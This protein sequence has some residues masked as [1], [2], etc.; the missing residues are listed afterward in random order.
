MSNFVALS[1]AKGLL[2]PQRNSTSRSFAALRTTALLACVATTL[3]AQQPATSAPISAMRYEVT[4]DKAALATRRLHVTTSF[5]VADDAVVLLSLPAWT[6]GAYEI[7]NFAKWVSAFHASEGSA[8]LRWD[9]LDYDT[10]RVRP[11]RGGRVSV[12]FEYSADSLDNA[13]SWTRPDFALFNGTNLFMYPEGRSAEFSST[14]VIKTDATFLVTTGLAGAGANHTYKAPNYHDLVDNPFFVG[15]FDLDSAPIAGKTVRY[16]TYPVGSVSAEARATAWEQLKRVIPV[17]VNVFGEAPWDNYT[18]MQIADSSYQGFSG[19]EHASSHVDIVSPAGIG[20]EFQP[21][22]YAHEI[23]HSW[24]VKR[25]RPADMVP[26]HYDRPQ[27]T[28]WLW[29]SEGITD[30]YADLAEMRGGVVDEAGFF[31]LTAAKIGE[32][33]TTVPFALE[34]ASVNTWVHPT[35]GTEYSYYPKGSLAGL[36][37]DIIVRD[38][39]DNKRSLDTVMRAL[40]ETTYKKDRGF[41]F[42]DFWGAVRRAANGRSFDDFHARY[43]DG[44][45]PYP[46]PE[47]LRTIGLRMVSDSLPR[48]GVSTAPDPAGAVRVMEVA[49]GTPAAAAG[50]QAGDVMVSVGDVQVADAQFG[51]KFRAQ[52]VGRPAGTPIPIVVRRGNDT[53]TLNGALA[54]APSAPRLE[55]DPAA[56]ARAVR[57]RDGILRGTTDR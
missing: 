53:L 37:L 7:T 2:F 26:Y 34:D 20:T 49:P 57:L 25:L 11:T 47:M 8:E 3:G 24:N 23:F 43:V 38:A 28:T 30:Y 6:P 56:P 52:Y 14:V 54:Y 41:G 44:R 40:Y 10:W 33:A 13:M 32:I 39:S 31:A 12:S 35:D 48:I 18:V 1:K 21:S 36:M 19:L 27:P 45:A 42:A 55:E 46:W 50:V 15:R 29:V 9:K 4:A 5:D 22:L 17:E 51:A 16:A